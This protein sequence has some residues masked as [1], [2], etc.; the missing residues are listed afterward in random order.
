MDSRFIQLNQFLVLHMEF[1]TPI[2][3]MKAPIIF[4]GNTTIN[5]INCYVG[6]NIITNCHI[7]GNITINTH[8]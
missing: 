3:S 7:N 8:G 2:Q 6:G 1:I 5:Y 4:S